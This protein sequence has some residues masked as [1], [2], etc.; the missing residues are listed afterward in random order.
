M[1]KTRAIAAAALLLV[2]AACGAQTGADLSA[3]RNSL[4]QQV[5]P[6]TGL[7]APGSPPI[8]GGY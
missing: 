2:L 4:G 1:V 8:G 5:D 3:P 6:K 7:P